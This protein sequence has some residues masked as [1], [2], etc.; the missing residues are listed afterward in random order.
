MKPRQD[1]DVPVWGAREKHTVLHRDTQRLSG[2]EKVQGSAKYSMDRRPEGMLFGRLVCVPIAASN[3]K[4]DLAPALAIEGVE[5]AVVLREGRTIYNGQAVAAVAARTPELAEDAARA[6]K[7]DITPLPWAVTPAQALAAN[8]P[9]VDEERPNRGPRG[10]RA[11]EFGD[12]AKTLA[13]L[14][15]ADFTVEVDYYVPVQHHACLEPHGVVADYRGG[16]EAIVYASTQV[17]FG[18]PGSA[19]EELG[20][21]RGDVR[22]IVEHMGGGF[23]SKFAM[24]VAGKAACALAKQVGKPVHLFNDRAQ[25]FHT[26]GNRSGSIQKI[27]AGVKQ[28]GTLCGMH[29]VMDKLGGIGSGAGT[30]Q[31][32][33]YEVGENYTEEYALRTHTDASRAMRAP[34]HPQVSFAIESTLDQLAYGIGADLVE[35]RKRNLAD[36]VY[37]RQLERTAREIGWYEHPHRTAPGRGDGWTAEGIG[38]GI[39]T[40]GGGGHEGAGCEVR[41]ERDGGVSSSIGVQDLGTGVRTL[42]AMITAE[43]LGLSVHDVRP[44]IGD[45]LLPT[46]VGSGGSVTTGSVSPVVKSAA[47]RARRAFAQHLAPLLG[48]QAQAVRFEGGRA[49][50]AAAPARALSWREACGTL[51]TEGLSAQGEWVGGLQTSGVHG[52][53]AAR[54]RVDLMTGGVEVLKMVAVQD[55]GLVLNPLTWRSQVNGA[56]IQA[57]GQALFEERVMD[58]DLGLQLNPNFA[59]YKI[60]GCQEIPELVALIDEEDTREAVIGVGEP[61]VI[62]GVGAI[63]NAVHNACGARVTSL[64]MTPD[65]VL[66]ALASRS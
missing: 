66:A 32:Y 60:P 37:H 42:V 9:Q 35:F 62:P 38:F 47:W 4:V 61:P 27:R 7:L 40:W 25:E 63:A 65:K 1:A 50:D 49:F 39:A 33:I 19:A 14:E 36:P 54:V 29:T 22:C 46:G 58:P 17:A 48:C 10:R 45:T 55:S 20:L 13:A 64:P 31:P 16:D 2:P 59:D 12:Q 51:P 41:I 3:V 28:D 53:Q 56:M 57:V 24:D 44:R 18:I 6:V 52:A 26:A 8:A 34:G 43:E 21:A 5:G 30:R 11:G 23:G 15:E